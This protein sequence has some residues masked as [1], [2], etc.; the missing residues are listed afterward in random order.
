MELRDRETERL[1]RILRDIGIES[2]KEKQRKH[3]IENL[4]SQALTILRKAERRTNQ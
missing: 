3:R 1:N 4:T 2:R